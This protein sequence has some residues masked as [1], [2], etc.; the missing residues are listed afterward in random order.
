MK[1]KNV[2]DS[3]F[4]RTIPTNEAATVRRPPRADFKRG[5]AC[6][7]FVLG[8]F[9]LLIQT[10][11]TGQTQ[12]AQPYGVNLL[13]GARNGGAE[14]GPASPSGPSGIPVPSWTTNGYLTVVP[15]GSTGQPA[16]FPATS[17]PGPN[18]RGNQFFSGGVGPVGYASQEIDLSANAAEIAQGKVMADLSAWLGGTGAIPDNAYVQVDFYNGGAKVGGG[19][20]TAVSAASRA[21]KS[22]LIYRAWS[23]PVPADTT[24]LIVSIV[25]T[26]VT[27]PSQ[28]D[29]NP[30][31]YGCADNISLVLRRPFTVTSTADSGPGSLREAITVGSNIGFSSDVFSLATAPHTIVLT[32]ALPTISAPVTIV[33]PGANALTVQRSTAAG[34]PKFS[35]FHI[36]PA[37]DPNRSF[38][39]VNVA[40]SG[41]TISNG[42][43]ENDGAFFTGGGIYCLASCSLVACT[44]SGNTAADLGGGLF[45]A[46]GN[47]TLNG[48]TIAGNSAANGGGVYLSQ[49]N[50]TGVSLHLA[51]STFSDNTDFSGTGAL[52]IAVWAGR[53]GNRMRPL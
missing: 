15:Y 36:E 38:A 49:L 18:D 27:Q 47:L 34:T 6:I 44:L 12:P 52:V 7:A 11:A 35:I 42:F 51:N 29:P 28:S 19:A 23:L 31:N 13:A 26:R 43:A 45:A 3:H 5:S 21:N 37:Y 8:A 41:L 50:P 20:L 32:S 24:R 22:G 53:S 16:G 40:F 46:L 14:Q 30:Y 39:L 9:I 48:C 1:S 4:A 17:D 10:R 25:I 33:G 2:R